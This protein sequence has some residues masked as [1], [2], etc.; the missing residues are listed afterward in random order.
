M[1][2]FLLSCQQKNEID[3]P[4][5][6][7][8]PTEE[9]NVSVEPADDAADE[10]APENE[11]M[12]EENDSATPEENE[13]DDSFPEENTNT[14]TPADYSYDM[15]LVEPGTFLM[16]SPE[17]EAGRSDLETQHEVQLTH[18]IYLGVVP[19]TREIFTT[20]M[21]YDPSS[22]TC[23]QDC[24]M[25]MI[26]WYEVAALAN[27]MS[28]TEGLTPCFTCEGE[29]DFITCDFAISDPYQ[30]DGYRMPTESEWEYAARAGEYHLYSGSDTA[31]DVGWYWDNTSTLQPVGLLQP[32][33]WG[34]YDMTGNIFEWCWDLQFPYP[35]GPVVDPV[36]TSGEYPVFRGGGWHSGQNVIRVAAR[37]RY[38]EDYRADDVGV[39][40]ARTIIE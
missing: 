40:L 20:L 6:T 7:S 5:H 25:T 31:Q 28:E 13:N 36:S 10:N 38:G 35:E 23:G 3:F 14:F 12:V 19:I 4:L 1:L 37:Y 32:N 39:R 24:P 16:G 34:F 8:P 33:N 11:E 26:N 22:D 30:C 18:S 29:G 27:I 9:P 2:L 17:T 21:G 15:I